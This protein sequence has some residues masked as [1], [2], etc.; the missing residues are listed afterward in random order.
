MPVRRPLS[1]GNEMR[2][3]S[4]S[5]G[6]LSIVGVVSLSA[7]NGTPLDGSSLSELLETAFGALATFLAAHD[8]YSLITVETQSQNTL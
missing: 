3:A 1:K 8:S 6:C 4:L 2:L 5:W 7:L